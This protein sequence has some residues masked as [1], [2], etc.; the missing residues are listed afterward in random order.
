MAHW[1]SRRQARAAGHNDRAFTIALSRETGARG[2]SVARALGRRLG[3]AVYDQ[4]LLKII[5][6][7][8]GLRENLVQSVDEKI[9]SWMRES[10]AAMS[11]DRMVSVSAYVHHLVETITSLGA[12]GNC[13]IV[14]R[15][16]AF[17]L[18]AETTL[19]VRLVAPLA[20]R[21]EYMIQEFKW[22]RHEAE[23][24]VRKTDGDREQ[25]VREYFRKDPTDPSLWDLTLNVARYTVE[26]SSELIAAALQRLQAQ[27]QP[28]QLVVSGSEG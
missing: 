11:F 23:K 8:M 17:I 24:R 27:A 20:D 9:I 21:V 12:H 6:E 26:Q 4:E 14:G 10:L 7:E 25:F 18:P 2:T 22:P 3:W 16:G 13:I 28:Q 19:R 15:G 5:A 1:D